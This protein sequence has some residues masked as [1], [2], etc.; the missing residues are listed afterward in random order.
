MTRYR[1]IV[2]SALVATAILAVA[3]LLC[4]S[5]DIPASEVANALIG[6][7][8]SRVT[9]QNII[10]E[11][12]LPA[13][14]TAALAGM[15]LAVAGLLMQT[16]FDNPLAGPSILGVATGASLGVAI[17][18][19]VAGAT[20]LSV[21]GGALV[22]SF[23]I[24]ALLIGL[25]L[26]LRSTLMLLIVGIMIGY[27]AS[28]AISLINF[29]ATEE[30]IHAFVFWGLGTFSGV[31][32]ADLPV[33]APVCIVFALA[34][35]LM[36]KP[37]NAMLLGDRYAANLGVDVRRART[38]MLVIAGTLTAAVTAW[39][40][41]ISFLG[42][43]V[44]HVARMAINSSDHSRLLPATVIFGLLFGLLTLWLSILPSQT[45]TIPVNA[46]TP[47]LGVPVIVYIN[48]FRRRLNYFN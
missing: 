38:M 14:I 48:I 39:C 12:R 28:S 6:K 31:A 4:G 34:A 42:L 41:P 9:W 36:V 26:V 27:L 3:T 18:V 45:S 37:L 11:L 20:T 29:F 40:G 16:A 33:F 24:I 19:M 2:A 35:F 21:L 10:V 1:I 46:I 17:V 7:G 23:A 13:T 5:V 32:R 8:A 47:L 22:G 15:S 43:A 25:S 30:S 44:P